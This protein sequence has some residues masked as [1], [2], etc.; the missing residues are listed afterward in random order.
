MKRKLTD[1]ESYGFADESHVTTQ[2]KLLVHAFGYI[3][4][5]VL[6]KI[7]SIYKCESVK[8]ILSTKASLPKVIL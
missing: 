8:K 2:T 3:K 4:A 1:N 6:E 7:A 5:E